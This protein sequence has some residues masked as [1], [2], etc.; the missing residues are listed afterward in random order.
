MQKDISHGVGSFLEQTG[1]V[2]KTAVGSAVAWESARLTGSTHP[3]LAPLTLILCLQATVG[4]S[5]RFALY[6]SVGTV[7]GVLLIGSFAKYIP[8]T[9]WALAVALLVSTAL[10]KLFRANDLLIHQVALSILFVLYFENHSSGYAWDRAKDTL[11]GAVVSAV[12]IL[13]LFPP[14]GL[15][16]TEQAIHAVTQR[17]IETVQL[18][19]DALQ[20]NQLDSVKNPQELLNALLDEVDEIT[21]SLKEFKQGAPFHFYV[22]RL[23]VE[24]AT[25]KCH[26]VRDACLHFVSLTRSFTADMSEEQREEWSDRLRSLALKAPGFIYGSSSSSD[27]T[28][29]KTDL[30]F[31]T[32]TH[33]SAAFEPT[34]SEHELYEIFAALR[35]LSRRS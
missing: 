3:Y 21:E 9:P 11:I 18:V 17:F 1:V 24:K 16:K 14:N 26:E 6:R 33:R 7:I 10:M 32:F 34:V 23:D 15:K 35:G 13:F 12:F 28:D 4:Q 30:R 29:D 5:L 8:V 31:A 27:K 2:W 20:R 25:Q 19:A 22:R